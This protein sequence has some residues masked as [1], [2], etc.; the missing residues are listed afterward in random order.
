MVVQAVVKASS[1]CYGNGQISSPP[2][3]ENPRTDFN[4]TWN[5]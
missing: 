2:W 4:E 3:L 1:Q 5:I